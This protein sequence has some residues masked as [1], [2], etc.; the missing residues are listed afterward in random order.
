MQTELS[1]NLIHPARF[2]FIE[3][4]IAQIRDWVFGDV[5]RWHRE[6]NTPIISFSL[7]NFVMVSSS[8]NDTHMNSRWSFL[9]DL[10]ISLSSLFAYY[11]YQHLFHILASSLRLVGLPL[12]NRLFYYYAL[13]LSFLF[14]MW[15]IYTISNELYCFVFQEHEVSAHLIFSSNTGHL[16]W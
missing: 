7:Y 2:G 14:D 3:D 5:R 13:S 12:F 1:W 8:R 11:I 15:S 9:G 6:F 16:I 4:I 10:S